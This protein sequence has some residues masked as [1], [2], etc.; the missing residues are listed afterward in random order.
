MK[1][2]IDDWFPK[3][4]SSATA[5]YQ[6]GK[7][8][9]PLSGHSFWQV[10]EDDLTERERFLL[11]LF[12][13]TTMPKET[14]PW[15]DYLMEEREKMPLNLL[16]LQFLHVHLWKVTDKH[17]ME[18]WLDMMHQL[19]PHQAASFQLS[20]QD[21]IFVLDQHRLLEIKEVLV[22]TIEAM[23]FDFGLRMTFFLGQIW[24]QDQD[25][26]RLFQSEAD[27]FGKWQSFYQSS[28]V[29]TFSQ[30][31]LWGQ[32]KKS[33]DLAYLGKVLSQMIASQ[34]QLTDIILALWEESAVLT[35]AAQ[36]LYLHRNTLQYRLE[37]WHEI[38]GLQ[39]K[40]LTDLSLCYSLILPNLF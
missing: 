39:L 25:L 22:D 28:T 8:N 7:I 2:T 40:E 35:K 12:E 11:S 18:D 31:F 1:H 16:R 21:Y 38:S 30:L 36:R 5:R 14:S 19:L 29:L 10:D 15:L 32:G 6:E 4:H 33:R 27:L 13:E 17:T 20:E 23:E 26:P 34:D 37:K 9:L 3:G 24:S